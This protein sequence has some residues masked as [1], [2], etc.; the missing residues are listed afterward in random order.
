MITALIRLYYV[1][2]GGVGAGMGRSELRK[3]GA[4]GS[5]GDRRKSGVYQ[6]SRPAITD[7]TL[8][9]RI[10]VRCAAILGGTRDV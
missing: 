10:P 6:A 7:E 9:S 1:G 2:W 5:Q 3:L 4:A 8:I